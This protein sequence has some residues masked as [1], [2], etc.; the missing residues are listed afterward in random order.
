MQQFILYFALYGA[1]WTN[2]VTLK[3]ILSFSAIPGFG[4]VNEFCA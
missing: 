2:S 3:D 1:W 4:L